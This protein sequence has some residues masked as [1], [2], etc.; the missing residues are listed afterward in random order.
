MNLINRTLIVMLLLFG[1][2]F[3]CGAIFGILFAR[4]QIVAAL[5]SPLNAIGSPTLGIAQLFCIGVGILVFA[6]SI[7]L[8]YLELMPTG[9]TRL[10]LKSIQGA[11]VVMSSDAITSQLQFA[12]DPLPG[13]I[14]AQPRVL[15]GKDDAVD[16]MLDLVTTPDVDIKRKTDEVM[17]V[18]RTVLEGGLGLRV[19]KVQIKIDQMK[20]PKNKVPPPKPAD[21]PSLVAIKQEQAAE[22]A[23]KSEL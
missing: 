4:E 13:V 17:D 10:K 15:K 19:G 21:L 12:L 14:K 7:L 1:V 23:A 11:D 2:L 22:N 20:P 9:K 6:F 18:T 5:Q 3:S 16:V 8:L